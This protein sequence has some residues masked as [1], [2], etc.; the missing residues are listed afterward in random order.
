MVT[1]HSSMLEILFF[2][3]I[4]VL[5]PPFRYFYFVLFIDEYGIVVSANSTCPTFDSTRTMG[6]RKFNG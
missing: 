6:T 5:N 1:T 2:Q 4:V 3:K